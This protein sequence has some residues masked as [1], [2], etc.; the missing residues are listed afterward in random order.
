M[1]RQEILDRLSAFPYDRGE[2]WIVA[3]A[4]M[5]VRGFREQTAD[6]DLGCSRKMADRLEADGRLYRRTADGK[7]WFRSGDSIE[8]FEDW[9]RDSVET[10]GG[11]QT[12]SLQGLIEMKRELGREKDLKDIKLI[13]SFME[14]ENG[15]E[16]RTIQII[17]SAGKMAERI[18]GVLD[19]GV[20][21]AWLYGSAVLDDFRPGWSDIDL[22]VL[23][24]GPIAEGQARELV[25]LR[26]TMSEAEP[27]N[28]YYRLFEGVIA[29]RDEYLSGSFTRLVYWGTTGQRITD[30]FLPDPFAAFELAKYGKSV[31]GPDDRSAFP[32]PSGEE[33]RAAVRRHYETIR[34]HAVQ[35]GDSLYSCGWLL[36]IARCVYTL[37][38]GG[39]IAKTQAGARALSEHL[40]E[41]EE[42]LRKTL[43]IR[44]NPTAYKDRED[45]KQWLK[46]LGPVVQRYADVL[47]WELEK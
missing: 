8:I 2:Y 21:S 28:P 38:D 1:N 19:H 6:I 44:R 22:L 3:G 23:T 30:R 13:R 35:T 47:E 15:P 20:H 4:A 25:T 39:V 34:Q 37:R 14:Q 24:N 45:V 5:V 26:Q 43:K 17:R 40:F 10:V 16:E 42:P 31:Y 12:V 18:G 41:D 7:R 29:C 36:D 11:F 32:V 9:L 27:D 33:M 46:S